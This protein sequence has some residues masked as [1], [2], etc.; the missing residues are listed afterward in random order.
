MSKPLNALIIEDSEDDAIL[1]VRELRH[2]GFD[3]VSERVDTAAA[4]EA[5]L[6]R[7]PWDVVIADYAMPHFS[8][9]D[10]LKVLRESGQ[11]LPFI[12]VSGTIGEDIAVEA[13]QNG[14]HDYLMK[15]KLARLFP[16]V[17]R[18]LREAEERRQRRQAEQDLRRAHDEL[19]VRVKE[20]TRE[21]AQANAEL[22]Q[23]R[24]E[25]EQLLYTVSHDLKSPLVTIQGFLDYLVRDVQAG[26]QDRVLS[27]SQR[28]Q[29]AAARMVRLID[30]LL[31]FSRIGRMTDKSVPI[32]LTELAREVAGS[33]AQELASGRIA[34]TIQD[35]MPSIMGEKHRIQ[36][37]FDNL[38]VNAIKYGSSAAEPR[39]EIGARQDGTEIH[40]FVKDN[41]KGIAPEFH[42]RIFD[43]FQRLDQDKDGVGVGLAIVKKIVQVHGGRVWVESDE[44]RGA[45]FWLAFPRT[46]AAGPPAD[47]P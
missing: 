25:M 16:A 19:D 41:G 29:N 33:H 38:L 13:M 15:G 34:V 43:L 20:R 5:A 11:D 24:A 36:Q 8:G 46:T 1:T 3:V 39:I 31:S 7:R 14:A 45:T 32:G 42:E 47:K 18:E 26:R 35:D 28:I 4:M 10:A 23:R 6:A 9:L 17:E 12:I 44:G 2:G 21:L 37:V 27:H 30:D 22:E 40:A